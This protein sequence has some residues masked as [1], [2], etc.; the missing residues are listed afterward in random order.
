[1]DFVQVRGARANAAG[2]LVR[3]HAVAEGYQTLWRRCGRA[4]RPGVKG[5][6][7]AWD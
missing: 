6:A 1:M 3:L 4:F 7:V 5:S 2:K